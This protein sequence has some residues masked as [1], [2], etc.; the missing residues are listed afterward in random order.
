MNTFISLHLNFYKRIVSC[1]AMFN[2]MII[3]HNHIATDI[4]NTDSA[5]G[6]LTPNTFSYSDE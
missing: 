5:T 3:C 4:Y 6:H 1:D 2:R